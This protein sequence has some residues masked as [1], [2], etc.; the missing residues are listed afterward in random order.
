MYLN[1][2]FGVIMGNVNVVLNNKLNKSEIEVLN[3]F[4]KV[5]EAMINKDENK[6]NEL[7]VDNYTLTH[8]SGKIQTK[9]EF[10]E[11]IMNNTLNYYSS[12]IQYP[13][14]IID[15][16]LA[17][18]TADV[19]LDAK[20]YGIKGKWTLHVITDFIKI[21]NKWYFGKWNN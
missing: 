15:G 5:Q 7:I 8:M 4:E 14:I 20:V 16:N 9:N 13:A 6:L 11:E 10:I 3:Q 2:F 21:D 18:L 19:T 12:L 17:Q 1:W